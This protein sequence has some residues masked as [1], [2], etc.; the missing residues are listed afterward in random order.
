Y[1]SQARV[2]DMVV[3]KSGLSK[4]GNTSAVFKQQVINNTTDKVCVDA[5]ITF[6]ITDFEGKPL[7]M[8]GGLK[9][10]LERIPYFNRPS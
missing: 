1:K 3:V 6:V 5:D 2:N 7:K 10:K 9:E 8:E 4:I